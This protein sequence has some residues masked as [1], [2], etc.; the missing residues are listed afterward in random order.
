MSVPARIIASADIFR[1]RATVRTSARTASSDPSV[2]SSARRRSAFAVILRGSPQMRRVVVF[3]GSQTQEK[4][5]PKQQKRVKGSVFFEELRNPKRPLPCVGEYL[6]CKQVVVTAC[7]TRVLCLS[8]LQLKTNANSECKCRHCMFD[9]WSPPL[10]VHKKTAPC[11][12]GKMACAAIFLHDYFQLH[13]LSLCICSV[14]EN[15]S[16]LP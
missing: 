15:K 9:P 2:F 12:D 13:Q 6:Q 14:T 3:G 7:T 10:L 16:W 5:F 1:R 8:V 11:C 4:N